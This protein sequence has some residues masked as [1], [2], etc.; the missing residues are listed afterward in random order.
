M[1]GADAVD[2]HFANIIAMQASV[3]LPEVPTRHLHPELNNCKE[4]Q[5]LQQWEL[6]G[7]ANKG[8]GS[9]WNVSGTVGLTY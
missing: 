5:A 7:A 8:N 3:A 6:W 1:E 4:A 9:R 2:R